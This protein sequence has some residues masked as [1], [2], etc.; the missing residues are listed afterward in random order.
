MEA[1]L[2]NGVYGFCEAARLTGLNG[3]RVREWFRTR[4]ADTKRRPVF[5][6]DYEPV[7]GDRA[8]SFF[9]LIDV[10]VVGQLRE[11]GVSLQTLRR[12]YSRLQMELGAK[13]PFCRSELL[14][15]GKIIFMRGMDSKGEEELKEVLTRQKVFPS[16]ILPFLR[17]IDYSQISKLAERWH[18]AEQVVIDPSICFGKPIVEAVSIP[19][20]ILASAYRANDQ[21]EELVGEW[22]NVHPKYVLAAVAFEDSMAA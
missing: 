9:D 15:D 4:N 21:D 19:T 11:H 13:H 3:E 10:F 14:S 18:I 8:V 1:K 5:Q 7:N 12:V 17:K 6:S 16:I 20:A 22:Y 2:G